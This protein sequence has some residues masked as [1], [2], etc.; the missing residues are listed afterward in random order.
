[1]VAPVLGLVLLLQGAAQG[2]AQGASPEVVTRSRVDHSRGVD[3]HALVVP[4]TVYVGQQAT[5]QLGVFLDQDTRQR[6]RRNPEFQ[7]PETRSLMSY[8]LRERSGSLSQNVDGR[9]YE[10]HV[11][12]RAV[13]P[14]TPG[15]YSI[16]QARLTY[17][18]P[19]NSSFFSREESFSLRSEAV[20]FVAI[21]PPTSG[22]PAD[23]AG[24]VGSWTAR[25]RVDTL[26]G[27]TGEPFVLTLRIEG[28]GNVTLLP[29]PKIA[30]P[31]ATVVNADERVKLDST[32]SLLGG[33]KEFD[34]LVTPA[35][36]GA[37][38]VPPLR[39]SYFNPRTKRYE[40]AE[41]NPVEVRVAVGSV[42]AP[43]EGQP[44]AAASDAELAIRPVLGDDTALPLSSNPVVLILLA[45]A[46]IAVL[47]SWMVRRPR[48]VRAAPTAKQQLASLGDRGDEEAVR[49]VRRVLVSGL[50]ARTSLDAAR[51]TAAGAW[52][53]ALRKAGVTPESS[54]AVEGL[55][56][57]LDAACFAGSAPEQPAGAGWAAQ[58]REALRLVDAEACGPTRTTRR[59]ATALVRTVAPVAAVLLTVSTLVAR[60]PA[61][62]RESFALGTTAYAGNDFVRAARHF[63][64]AAR[65]A[66][67]AANAWANLGTAA[68]LAHD[69]ANAVLGWQRALRLDPLDGETRARLQRI[70]APQESGLARVPPV[71]ARLPSVLAL[72]LWVAGWTAA[73]RQ[74]WG[75]RPAWRLVT[76]TLLVGGA[77]VSGARTLERRLEGI[78]LAVVTSPAP[79]RAVPALGADTRATP[80]VGEI[81]QVLERRGAWALLRLDGGRDGWIPVERISPLG[82]D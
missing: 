67:R 26:R 63:S 18:L 2:A 44:E 11:F 8:D 15:R 41:S 81:T 43:I 57:A 14:L 74:A 39:Y 48:R 50:Q 51:L 70:R 54:A 6:I 31:W 3:F 12:R 33:A 5:Y 68:Y 60:E 19:Q 76:A 22:R 9:P 55:M 79:L 61:D 1:M 71:P 72:V 66:P 17:A 47:A 38:R 65:T 42:A 32:P 49:E 37:Q 58:A 7:P 64:D 82:R 23:W 20:S 35:T 25:A 59:T 77:A 62:A 73:A 30:I 75:R 29:R 69:T 46:P 80:M 13:F 56:L 34:W 28:Q 4:E 45:L 16:P 27:R 10:I 24:A 53:M 52:T 78:G 40:S 21:E 36:P